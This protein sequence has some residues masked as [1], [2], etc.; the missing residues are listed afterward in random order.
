MLAESHE[1]RIVNADLARHRLVTT[2]GNKPV[3][4]V[5]ALVEGST[6]CPNCSW[7]FLG[8]L[9]QKRISILHKAG[10]LT[11]TLQ[12]ASRLVLAAEERPLDHVFCFLEER[13]EREAEPE[14][15]A[16]LNR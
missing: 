6:A 14:R 15:Y 8:C 12:A 11:K 9:L 2:R 16:Q 4:S 5:N 7:N 3:A 13:I 10:L 1:C